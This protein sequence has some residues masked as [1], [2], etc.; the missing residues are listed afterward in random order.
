MY[1][2]CENL[3]CVWEDDVSVSILSFPPKKTY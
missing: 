3:T 1:V 2:V